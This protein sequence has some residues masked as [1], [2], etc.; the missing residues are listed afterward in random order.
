M[1]ELRMKLSEKYMEMSEYFNTAFDFF[2]YFFK[3]EKKWV[4]SIVIL[5][6]MSQIIGLFSQNDLDLYEILSA[7]IS[8]VASLLS[9]FVMKKIVK[10]IEE[11]TEISYWKMWLKSILYFLVIIAITLPL[12][13][14]IGILGV[15]F[16]MSNIKMLSTVITILI[17][18]AFSITALYYT[19]YFTPLYLTRDIGMSDAFKY[20]LH[21]SKGNR[22]RMFI[23]TFMIGTINL[24]IIGVSFLLF[25]FIRLGFTYNPMIQNTILIIMII[26]I[27]SFLSFIS[28]YSMVL[29]I[30]IYL[31]VEYMDLDK[32]EK[33][34]SENNENTTNNNTFLEYYGEEGDLNFRKGDQTDADS[35]TEILEKAKIEIRNMGIEQWQKGYPNRNIVLE[36]IYKGN[37]YV[38]E[39]NGEIVA[40]A[41]L[42]F[43]KEEPYT[44][45]SEGTWLTD[46]EYGVIHRIAVDSQFKNR[47]YSSELLKKLEEVAKEKGIYSIKVDTHEGNGSMRRLLEKNGYIYCGVVYLDK[48]P[49]MGQKRI[50]FEK[51]LN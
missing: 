49:E 6:I 28:L 22:L 18:A 35:I 38:L 1:K 37:S 27:G 33:M 17:V 32:K 42:T 20:N 9:L 15:I 45:L 50:A 13:I 29:N 25:Y 8:I 3:K 43:E 51:V 4:F 44:N 34:E 12:G 26:I 5:N 16:F 2:K 11:K 10:T 14:L 36:D 19:L 40:V 21:L 46:G 24:S 30:I 31:N 23:P 39:K 47:G 41:T 48:E 7:V